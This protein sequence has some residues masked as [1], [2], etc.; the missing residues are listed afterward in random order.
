[1]N[2]SLS[3]SFDDV[4]LIPKFSDISSRSE[5]DTSVNF[6][7]LNL[8]FPLIS[9][10]MDSVTSSEMAI[11][12][13]K[14]GAISC[15]HRFQTIAENCL[16]FEQSVDGIFNS[17]TSNKNIPLVSIGIGEKELDRA[18]ELNKSG[19]KR[20]VIDVAHGAAQHVV[21][22]YD[23]LRKKLPEDCYIVVGNFATEE[24]VRLFN[25]KSKCERKP[26]AFKV[27]VGGGSMCTT[28][29]V[30]GCGMPTF[31]SVV[32]C[33]KSGYPIIADGGIRTSGDIVKALAAGATAIM[34]GQLLAGTDEAPGKLTDWLPFEHINGQA[35]RLIRYKTYR[36]SASKESYEVQGKTASHRAPE[37][38]STLIEYKGPVTPILEQLQAGVKSGLSY[39]GAKSL[40]ELRENSEFITITGNGLKESQPH[41][42]K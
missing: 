31:A 41:G 26:D 30:T 37:G 17:D 29:V 24:G 8:K 16:Q 34:V 25:Y 18:L 11:A 2:K 22:M 19:A 28:R 6:L 3:L 35:S 27:G 42:Q 7:G 10:N 13:A 15:L 14:F 4:L 23:S 39:V 20:F 9:S 36:G 40:K 32:D 21:D 38:S 1:M 12:L 33:V 5:V